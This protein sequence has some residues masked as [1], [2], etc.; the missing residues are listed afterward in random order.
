MPQDVGS[1][2]QKN[3]PKKDLQGVKIKNPAKPDTSKAVTH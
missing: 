3:T 2:L 1:S